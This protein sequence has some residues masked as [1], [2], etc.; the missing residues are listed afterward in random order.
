MQKSTA[1]PL[2]GR[3]QA[4][5]GD[6]QVWQLYIECA[7]SGKSREGFVQCQM[8]FH[9]SHCATPSDIRGFGSQMASAQPAAGPS[10]GAQSCAVISGDLQCPLGNSSE[11]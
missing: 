1:S 9:H 5:Q 3:G 11:G 6:G 8:T 4:Q 2:E 7:T 10:K